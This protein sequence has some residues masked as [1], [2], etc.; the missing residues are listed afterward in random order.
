MTGSELLVLALQPAAPPP[1]T[2]S[3]WAVNSRA[4]ARSL[5]HD[6]VFNTPFLTVGFPAGCLASL[7]GE[8]V[9]ADDSVLV[10]LQPSAGR[11]GFT[12]SP[13]TLELTDV[14][15]ATGELSFGRY[16]DLSVADGS[17]TYLDWGAYAAALDLWREVSP[18]RWAIVPG[19]HPSG[20]DAIEGVLEA[21]GRYV[22]AAPR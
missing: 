10:T 2:L 17:S 21:A 19:S 11:Y 6:D 22:L 9:A 7:N 8:A 3:F 12:L 5:V 18:D 13:A 4:T 14:C 1:Q 15:G 20:N 16:G